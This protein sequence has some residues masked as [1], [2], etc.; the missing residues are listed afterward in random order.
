MILQQL[1]LVAWQYQELVLE[2]GIQLVSMCGFLKFGITFFVEIHILRK[3]VRQKISIE[4]KWNTIIQIENWKKS[5]VLLS[6]KLKKFWHFLLQT[7]AWRALP[8]YS[9]ISNVLF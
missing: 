3:T 5:N 1:E 2:L 8:S 4:M 7:T 9:G 6:E